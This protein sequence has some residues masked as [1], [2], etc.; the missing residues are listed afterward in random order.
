M[1]FAE[2]MVDFCSSDISLADRTE[3]PRMG[4]VP[5]KV[6][7]MLCSSFSSSAVRESGGRWAI[8]VIIGG[9]MQ[10]PG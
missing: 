3:I 9:G 5:C 4:S 6:N 7:V 2:I 8:V 10:V 1:C